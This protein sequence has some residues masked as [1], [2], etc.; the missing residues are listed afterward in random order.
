MKL[1]THFHSFDILKSELDIIYN[2]LKLSFM[3]ISRFVENDIMIKTYHDRS[4]NIVGG[5][6]YGF[7]RKYIE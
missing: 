1:I 2:R 5:N 7:K 3:S 4:K 6:K